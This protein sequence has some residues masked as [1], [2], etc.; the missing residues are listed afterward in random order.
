MEFNNNMQNHFIKFKTLYFSNNECIDP[1]Q[2][3]N[4]YICWKI[5]INI[6]RNKKKQN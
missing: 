1:S 3:N 4:F 2:Q 6:S 5:V